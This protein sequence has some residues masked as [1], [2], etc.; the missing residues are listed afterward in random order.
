MLKGVDEMVDSNLSRV[1][2]VELFES[3]DEFETVDAIRSC[4]NPC[5]NFVEVVSRLQVVQLLSFYFML[6]GI[7]GDSIVLLDYGFHSGN[8]VLYVHLG[9]LANL[10]DEG[11]LGGVGESEL[12]EH[13]PQIC[14]LNHLIFFSGLFEVASLL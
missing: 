5:L 12:L 6:L 7:G 9:I 4:P 10:L 1:R 11:R 2:G 3:S 14:G 13:I 8:Q